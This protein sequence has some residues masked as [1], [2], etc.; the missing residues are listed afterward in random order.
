MAGGGRLLLGWILGLPRRAALPPLPG[1]RRGLGGGGEAAGAPRYG[2]AYTCKVCGRRAA[3]TVSRAAYERGVVIATCPGCRS[4]H[5]IADHLGWFAGL[6]GH[7][8]NIEEIL[9][10]KGETVKRVVG[11]D[12]LELFL[13]NSDSGKS[14]DQT[15]G[16]VGGEFLGPGKDPL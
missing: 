1:G 4:R 12:G 14:A 16:S 3:Q 9:A 6:P 11:G 15:S 13:E 5:L 8:R 10:A 2:L 7:G